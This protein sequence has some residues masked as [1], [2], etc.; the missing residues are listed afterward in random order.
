MSNKTK[1]TTSQRVVPAPDEELTAGQRNARFTR[2]VAIVL[3]FALIAST[4][5][6]ALAFLFA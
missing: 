5:I 2:R 1:K 3:V 4:A 6:P